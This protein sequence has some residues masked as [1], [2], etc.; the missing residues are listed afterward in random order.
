MCVS[1][2]CAVRMNVCTYVCTVCTQVRTC[3]CMYVHTVCTYVYRYVCT[4]CT[5][6]CMYVRTYVH[7]HQG[8]DCCLMEADGLHSHC[9]MATCIIM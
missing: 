9:H 8:L 5:N 7:M 6:V 2:V 1:T 4:V 3:I